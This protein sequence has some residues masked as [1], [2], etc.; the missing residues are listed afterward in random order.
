MNP[1]GFTAGI[2]LAAGM[3]TRYGSAK[4]LARIGGKYLVEKVA[5]AAIGSELDIV[6]LVLGHEFEKIMKM[7]DSQI[8]QNSRIQVVR[9]DE[10]AGGMSTSLR[11]GLMHVMRQYSSVMF[12]LG[13][14]P[15]ITSDLINRLLSHFYKSGKP[16]C[17][18]ICRNIRRNPVVFNYRFYNEI[19]QLE[20]DTGARGIIEK[21]QDQVST[22]NIDSSGYFFDID[23]RSD[24]ST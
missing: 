12:L 10:Y 22:V 18:P 5:E 24:G 21:Y 20:G 16:I 15:F 13:D 19:L 8:I 14:Q 6:I 7:I 11:C 9:N 17:A 1:H 23:R 3:S 2:I 4:Q